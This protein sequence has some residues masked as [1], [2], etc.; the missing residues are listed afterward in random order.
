LDVLSVVA[1]IPV[2]SP[3]LHVGLAEPVN[4]PPPRLDAISASLPLLI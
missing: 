1:V 2:D 4:H 3:L